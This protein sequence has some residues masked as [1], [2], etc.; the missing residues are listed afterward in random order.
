M[1]TLS[2]WN[3]MPTQ[4]PSGSKAG[5]PELPELMAASICT[6]GDSPGA[7]EMAR[8]V[9]AE[10]ESAGVTIGAFAGRSGTR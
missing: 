1:L 4:A 6:H 7:V 5:P 8:A 10:L 2:D 3:A 9:R